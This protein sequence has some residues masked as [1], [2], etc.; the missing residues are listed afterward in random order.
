MRNVDGEISTETTG[1]QKRFNKTVVLVWIARFFPIFS[2][3]YA[4]IYIITVSSNAD[5]W[6]TNSSADD[7]EILRR[8][9]ARGLFVSILIA[10]LLNIVG[11]FMFHIRVKEGL[12]ITNYGFILGPVIQFI[13]DQAIASDAGFKDAF[14]SAGIAYA[15]SS[16]IDGNFM[17]YIITVFL[18]LFISNPLQ[19]ILKR[20]AKSIG[21][22]DFLNKKDENKGNTLQKLD[23]F[24]AIN[25]PSL[26]QSVVGMVTF[27]AYTNQT[28]F[29]WAYPAETL[30]RELRIP[31]G[32]IMLSTAIA[33]LLYLNF[34]TI[35]DYLSE[36]EYFDI[37][38]KLGYVMIIFTL[39]C[40]L[41]G[42]DNIEAPVEGEIDKEYTKNLE[43]FKPFCG[44]L[45]FIGFLIYGFVYPLYTRL[46]CCGKWKPTPKDLE[47]DIDHI[48][49]EKQQEIP[50]ILIE[51]IK[52][53]IVLE[54]TKRTMNGHDGNG[55]GDSDSDHSSRHQLIN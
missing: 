16:L 47:K 31:P 54:I 53:Q 11:A 46:G 33:G 45:V 14:T 28:R 18:D 2:G 32:T 8:E 21:I 17:R 51:E 22:I 19:D 50:I 6:K 13:L 40:I 20:Q 4:V 49:E 24:V 3:L 29:G 23:N 39:L 7:A 26:L 25:F 9:S 43:N 27:N 37:N 44:F 52:K 48:T 10:I 15:F 12:V 38:T 34:Y 36:R 41:N 1:R 35:M 5:N 42:T 30:D 55:S